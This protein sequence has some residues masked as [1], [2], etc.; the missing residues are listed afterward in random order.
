MVYLPTFTTQINLYIPVPW[1]VWVKKTLC[2][3]FCLFLGSPATIGVSGD[4]IPGLLLVSTPLKNM[5]VKMGIFPR[6]WMKIKIY[7]SCHHPVYIYI[8]TYIPGTP[9]DLYF[10]RSTPQKQGPNS[11]QN[12]GTHLGSR[13]IYMYT[14]TY[15]MNGELIQTW[16][17]T[18][19]HI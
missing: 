9:N 5:L 15:T 10:W 19:G 18:L 7:L 16:G 8:Y 17:I 3:F 12:K 11:N 13:Y 6:I 1:M 14:H 4:D 2:F